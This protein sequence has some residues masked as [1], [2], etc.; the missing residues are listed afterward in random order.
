MAI[1]Y[2]LQ[3]VKNK[4][5]EKELYM[6]E[7]EYINSKTKFDIVDKE[8]YKYKI[9]FNE[10]IQFHKQLDKF[11][12]Y[13]PFTIENIKI[14]SKI[15]GY[16]NKILS[17]EYKSSSQKLIFTCEEC[18][19]PY[20]TTFLEFRNRKR[21]KCSLCLGG[22]KRDKVDIKYAIDILYQY[23]FILL[24]K[25]EFTNSKAKINIQDDIGY[26][27]YIS[28]SDFQLY[29]KE[30]CNIDKFSKF[31]PHTIDNIKLWLK[32]NNC[33]NE[34]L[35]T[36]YILCDAS[37]I[38]TCEECGQPY[39]ATFK[40]FRNIHQT[41]CRCCSKAESKLEYLT[42]KCLENNNINFTQQYKIDN[43]KDILPL[44]FDFAILN[45]KNELKYLIECDGK[46]HFEII[47]YFG[48]E[49]GFIYTKTHDDIKNTYCKDN[50]ISL[51]RIPYWE[52][53][54]DN[55]INILSNKLYI[56]V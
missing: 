51:L 40:N 10:Y 33:K 1:K 42:K 48:G 50:N 23:N 45:N 19:K 9:S 43:C 3:Q 35:S 25:D 20:E 47:D 29:K 17:T 13:N 53:K 14:W 15:N 27:Y 5:K 21:T 38:F 18:G 54:N 36:K 56:Q 11:S 7:N 52:F 22:Y 37:L 55:Y 24:N 46:Q 26:K 39:E 6:I 28:L 16:K 31:N 41:K 32:L 30:N 2:T 12:I 8:G 49:E 4:L 44:P 34:L